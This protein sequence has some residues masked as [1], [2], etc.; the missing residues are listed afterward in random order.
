MDLDLKGKVALVT[1][2]SKGI[3]AAVAAQLA[4]EGCDVHIAARSGEQLESLAAGL[5]AK[6]GVKITPHA[7]D[8][9]RHDDVKTL[10]SACPAPDILV[11]NAGAIPGGGLQ[12]IDIARWKAAYDLKMFGYIGLTQAILPRMIERRSGVVVCVI[13]AAAFRPN[14]NYIAGCMA[15]IALNMFVSCLGG[16]AFNHGV[17]VCAVNPGATASERAD[18]LQRELARRKF[19]DPERYTELMKDYP[20]GRIATC[21]EIAQTVAFLASDKSSY[22]SGAQIT[23]DAGYRG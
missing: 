21:E 18:Y 8:L 7:C 1:G 17:R 13:G 4:A 5:R 19:G 12:D 6:H 10:A 23:I 14:P 11:N 20:G 9:S 2:A 16:E 22:T 15:N 3:G